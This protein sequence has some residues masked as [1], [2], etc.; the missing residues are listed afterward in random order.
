MSE[1][2]V[3]NLIAEIEEDQAFVEYH[4]TQWW[5]CAG[6]LDILYDILQGKF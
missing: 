2:A 5:F 3:R 6:Q 4:S 1:T